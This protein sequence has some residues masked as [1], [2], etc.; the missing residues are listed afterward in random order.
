MQRLRKKKN[1]KLKSTDWS[2]PSQDLT[3]VKRH[4]KTEATSFEPSPDHFFEAMKLTGHLYWVE[5]ESSSTILCSPGDLDT[6]SSR[7]YL[8]DTKPVR[9]I[10]VLTFLSII[11]S[12]LH[13]ATFLSVKLRVCVCFVWENSCTR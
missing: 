11:V 13:D 12:A 7:R 10:H 8:C 4:K 5:K 3:T 6:R 9:L 1:V 2:Q